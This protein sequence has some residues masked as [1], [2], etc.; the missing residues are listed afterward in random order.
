MDAARLVEEFRHGDFLLATDERTILGAGIAHEVVDTDEDALADHVTRL[1]TA[2][3][4]ESDA[5]ELPTAVGVLPFDAASGTPARMVVPATLRT[6]GPPQPRRLRRREVPEPV[7]IGAVPAEEAHMAAVAKA[8]TE[9]GVR[10]LR[11]V[12]LARALDVEFTEPVPTEAVVGNLARDNRHGYVFAAGLPGDR[13]LV[14]ASPE[15]LIARHGSRVVSHPYAGSMPR[16]ADSDAD[17]ANARTLLDSKKDREEHAVLVDAVTETLRP[18]CRHLDVPGEPTL[19]RTPT[20]WHLGTRIVGELAD[21]EVT[22]LHLAVALHPTPAICGTPTPSAR[23]LV[24]ELEPFDRGYYAGAV[25]WV[26]ADGDGEWAVSIRCADTGGRD[27][28]MYAGGGIVPD[29]DPHAELD[30]TSAK[31]ATL[32]RAMGLDTG[33]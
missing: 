9:L 11:K 2:A 31:F 21:P 28:R 7:A 33:R 20:M 23:E 25:G 22:A 14:G 24:R 6:A 15:L 4:S 8:V 16:A 5:G 12:V 30:E 27:L 13:A 19:E 17:A 26:D 29:S 1:L 10:D 18:F 32:A 3:R